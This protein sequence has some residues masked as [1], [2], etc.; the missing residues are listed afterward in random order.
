MIKI[1]VYIEN[2]VDFLCDDVSVSIQL[3][4]VPRVGERIF[5]THELKKRLE[6]MAKSSL[7]IANNYALE[8][9]YGKSGSDPRVKIMEAQEEHLKD[10]SFGDAS[11][12]TH[13]V[14]NPN[15]EIVDIELGKW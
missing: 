3:P 4:A 9:F 5:L 8:W 13:V 14:Y 1:R 2:E 11:V 7:D 10:L 12:V 6:D 15:S